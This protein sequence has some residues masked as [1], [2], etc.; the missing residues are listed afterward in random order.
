MQEFYQI[1]DEGT[2]QGVERQ[3]ISLAHDHR[4]NLATEPTVSGGE[5][6]WGAWWAR[7]GPYLDG[8]AFESG[9]CAE[10]GASCWPIA[11]DRDAAKPE[12][13]AACRSIVEL[14]E[15]RKLLGK[16]FYFAWDEPND[17]KSYAEIRRI[18]QW[19]DEAVGDKLPVMV[20]ESPVPEDAAW[21]S[22][23]GAVDIFC[24]MPDDERQIPLAKARGEQVWVYNGGPAGGPYIDVRPSAWPL[25]GPR[26]ALR[27]GWL[28]HVG[29]DLLAAEALRPETGH[30]PLCRPADL[31][32][33]QTRPRRRDA[34]PRRL[35]VAAER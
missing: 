21:G 7:Y 32:R 34:V 6:N 5:Y 11:A 23:V 12:F 24:G 27:A 8:S 3:F 16:A 33:D 26:L 20:T 28:V 29:R 31:R 25:G 10:V 30:R 17:A 22:L 4:M 1:T 9:P 14:C 35:G 15:Q 18:G 13:L 2:L 19:V